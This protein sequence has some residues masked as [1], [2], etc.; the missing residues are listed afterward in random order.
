MLWTCCFQLPPREKRFSTS[1]SPDECF[2]AF[3]EF[4]AARD[5]C[6]PLPEGL[7]GTTRRR[8]HPYEQEV[9]L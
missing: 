1:P 8:L 3:N 9:K 4:Y 5:E 7:F 6:R 2:F